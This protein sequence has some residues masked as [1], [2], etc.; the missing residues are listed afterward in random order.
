MQLAH[1]IRFVPNSPTLS[2]TAKALELKKAG[3][4]VISLSIGEPDF[5]TPQ[6]IIDAA[7]TALDR[8]AT[9]YTPAAGIPELREAVAAE[10]RRDYELEKITSDHVIISSGAKHSI[11]NAMMAVINPGDEV[12]I[13]APYW[14]S[15]PVIVT[16]AGGIPV[17]VPT[18]LEDRF[19]LTPDKLRNAITRRTK[20]VI[21]NNPGNPTGTVY[22]RK[23]LKALMDVV[24]DFPNILVLEDAIYRKLVYGNAKFVS[25]AC[26]SE[27]ARKRTIII[28]GVSKAYAMTGWRIGFSIA[29]RQITRAMAHI[30]SHTTSNPAAVSQYASLAALTGD[31]G[32]VIEMVKSF[33]SRRTTMLEELPKITDFEFHQ[34]RGAFYVLPRIG[35]VLGKL[36]PKDELLRTDIDFANYLID[37]AGVALVP[38]TPFGAPSH[39]RLSYALNNDRIAAAIQRIGN[40]TASLREPGA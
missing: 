9:K 31:Q 5:S 38:G 2:I 29:R 22:N 14:L 26:F 10:V 21:L 19:V 4:D 11:Y 33:A 32:P 28:D 27:E 18:T 3:K 35:K 6:H 25:A 37:E 24:M 7:K 17:F 20:L 13:P 1:R 39:I 40:A 15:Y 23:E 16:L 36:T 12:I 34:P 30:Q 8:G